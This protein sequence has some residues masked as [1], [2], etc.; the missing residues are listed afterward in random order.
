MGQILSAGYRVKAAVTRDVLDTMLSE[1]GTD[2]AG[3]RDRAL[4]LVGFGSGGRRRSELTRATVEDL[5]K[6]DVTCA[7][8]LVG[9]LSEIPFEQRVS[10]STLFSTKHIGA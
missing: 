10:I 8:I 7:S 4:L 2:A 6:V 3:V 9:T 5:R 1:C